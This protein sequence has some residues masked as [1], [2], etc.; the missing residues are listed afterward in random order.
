MSGRV[1]SGPGLRGHDV[2]AVAAFAGR[3]TTGREDHLLAQ[4]AV[5][6]G[7]TNVED[8]AG[9][10]RERQITIVCT[11]VSVVLDIPGRQHRWQADRLYQPTLPVLEA[12]LPRRKRG[13]PRQKPSTKREK[14]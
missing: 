2:G 8:V 11:A 13:N 5:Q 1:R 9:R 7:E 12:L 14:R 4:A 6:L 3:G 10:L